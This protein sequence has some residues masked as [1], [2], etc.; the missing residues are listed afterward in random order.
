MGGHSNTHDFKE[1][2]LAMTEYLS[3]ILAVEG[4]RAIIVEPIGV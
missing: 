3:C 4:L 2:S 1:A